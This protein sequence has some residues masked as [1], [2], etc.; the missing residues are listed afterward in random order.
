MYL[1]KARPGLAHPHG[2]GTGTGTG[3]RVCVTV[4]ANIH[5]S[6]K[7]Q[8]EHDEA[9]EKGQ[10]S[11]LRARHANVASQTLQ[12]AG[13]LPAGPPPVSSEHSEQFS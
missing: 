2:P 5:Q 11:V 9:R 10:Y 7:E 3:I 12:I 8:T 6:H 13:N 4:Q 1:Y